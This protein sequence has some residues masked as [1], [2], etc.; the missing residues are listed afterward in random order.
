MKTTK[1]LI[2]CFVLCFFS[3]KKEHLYQSYVDLEQQTWHSDSVVKFNIQILDTNSVCDVFLKIRHTT[4]YK[5][6]NLF[7][8]FTV[9]KEDNVLLRDTVEIY[10]HDKKGK[11]LGVGFG[12]NKEVSRKVASSLTGLE[13]CTILVEQAMRY[14]NKTKMEQLQNLKSVGVFIKKTDE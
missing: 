13:K 4:K 7:V 2:S 3:C 1:I 14:G 9:I 12:D 10:L 8:F 11:P 5:Y 6:Q